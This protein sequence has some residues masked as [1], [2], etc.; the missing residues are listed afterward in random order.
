MV[1]LES[2]KRKGCLPDWLVNYTHTPTITLSFT[3]SFVIGSVDGN[4]E[5]NPHS[6]PLSAPIPSLPSQKLPPQS[7][8]VRKH[9]V[10]SITIPRGIFMLFYPALS[11]ESSSIASL[12]IN[13]TFTPL[14]HFDF[15]K[16]YLLRA[17]LSNK[18]SLQKIKFFIQNT[19]GAGGNKQI[20]K[21]PLWHFN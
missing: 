12:S 9:T 13:Y 6:T 16:L 7:F 4:C 15:L 8:C 1:G 3:I 21:C 14:P 10:K 20:T 2:S 5:I 19:V 11:L 18:I 17:F